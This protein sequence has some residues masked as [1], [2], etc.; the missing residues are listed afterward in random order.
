V[1]AGLLAL[2]A[3]A[4]AAAAAKYSDRVGLREAAGG[5]PA[6]FLL[7]I[8]AIRFGRQATERHRRTLGRAGGRVL[9]QVG[10][11]LGSVALL[12]SLTAALAFG[13]Y[14]VLTLL[15]D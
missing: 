11:L 12:V 4:G 3:L 6:G 14:A 13:V 7:G 9:S 2:A 10:R 5:V 15:L 1:L 8:L